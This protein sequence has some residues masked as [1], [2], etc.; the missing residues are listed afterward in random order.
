MSSSTQSSGRVDGHG[1]AECLV[2][3][4]ED[5]VE[6]RRIALES[7]VCLPDG[8]VVEAAGHAEGFHDAR[9][10]E[11]DIARI[12]DAPRAE[13]LLRGAGIHVHLA[14]AVVDA[15]VEAAV[16][17]VRRPAQVELIQ[18]HFLGLRGAARDLRTEVPD[19]D[20]A[21]TVAPSARR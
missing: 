14:L 16:L 6:L 9:R 12:R 5:A 11:L 8:E 7:Y 20:D 13:I 2:D 17:V 10:K 18:V 1:I 15:D 21:V 19:V 3:R 4:R